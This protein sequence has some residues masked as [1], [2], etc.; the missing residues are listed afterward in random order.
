MRIHFK[1]ILLTA[2]VAQW[3][4]QPKPNSFS[5]TLNLSG[6]TGQY[7][8]WINMT[9]NVLAPDSA[10]MPA[11]GDFVI[12]HEQD[13]PA[14]YIF[15]FNPQQSIRVVAGINEQVVVKA[16]AANLIKSYVVTGSAESDKLLPLLKSQYQANFVLDTLQYFYLKNQGQPNFNEVV[17]KVNWLAD[18]IFSAQRS[19]LGEFI[20]KNPGTIAAYIA[21][22]QKIGLNSNMFNVT[23]DF[24]LFATVDTALA[25]EYPGT[26]MSQLLTAYVTKARAARQIDSPTSPA[27]L[28]QAAPDI[29]LPNPYGDSL[30]LSSIKG[31]YVLVDFWASWCAPCRLHNVTLRDS[32][33]RYSARG[34]EIFQVA[35]ERNR[36]NWKNTIREDRLYWRYQVSELNY[37]ESQTA[38][39]Y[40]VL[41][42]PANFLVAPNGQ[43]IAVNLYGDALNHVLDSV[44]NIAK[45]N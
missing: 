40:K 7:L 41:S 1:I 25:R 21:L 38:R 28:N 20:Q 16:D 15:Y 17:E 13:Y 19:Y 11:N 24:E 35:L 39:Q 27:P 12:Q 31:K 32:Y 33:R 45:I 4:C 42:I 44:L 23:S 14:D 9:S 29:K 2:L 36:D 6:S 26:P 30:Q 5:I 18:S 3:G 22:S 10:K 34:F 37:M 43:I 8:K